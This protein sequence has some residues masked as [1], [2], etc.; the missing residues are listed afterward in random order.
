METVEAKVKVEEN[1]K[2]SLQ[3]KGRIRRSSQSKETK[4][5]QLINQYNEELISG[6]ILAFILIALGFD[7][8]SGD[9]GGIKC[10]CH[11]RNSLVAVKRIQHNDFIWV[12][13]YVP[14]FL[15]NW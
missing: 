6:L 2:I 9:K 13:N 11:S 10:I 14:H 1:P 12:F 4:S 8:I 5:I 15:D 3:L 7:F